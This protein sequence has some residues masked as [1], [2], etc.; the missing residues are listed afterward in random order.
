MWSNYLTFKTLWANSADD[1]LMRYFFFVFFFFFQENRTWHFKQI[2]SETICMNCRNL[3]SG[4]KKKKKKKK[5][6]NKKE[7]YYFN[8]SS[9]ES[10]IHSA[11]H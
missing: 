7:T 10:F 11:K 5:K 1:K 9:A 6:K 2:V 8:M 4:K 3:F